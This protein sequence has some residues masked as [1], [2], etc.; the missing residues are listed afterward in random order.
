M[1]LALVCDA[2]QHAHLA[3][4][5]HRDLK[6]SNILVTADGQPKVLDFGVARVARNDGDVTRRTSAGELLGTL[7]YMSPEQVSGDPRRVDARSDVYALGVLLYRLL[8]GMLPLDVERLPVP[9]A[10]RRIAEDDPMRLGSIDRRL[11][12]DLEVIAQKALEKDRARRYQSA[13]ELAADLRR[14]LADE[15]I[16]ARG[17]SRRYQLVKFARRHR[18]LAGGAVMASLALVAG[19]VA[20]IA[21]AVRADSARRDAVDESERAR[22]ESLTSDRVVEFLVGL[23]QQAG[24]RVARGRTI[25]AKEVL[26]SGVLRLR[27]ELTDEPAVRA[28]LVDTLVAVYQELGLFRDAAS[29]AD[30]ALRLAR[31]LNGDGSVAHAK[32]LIQRAAIAYALSEFSLSRA[33]LDDAAKVLA[34]HPDAESAHTELRLERAQ[35]LALEGR[36]AE[37]LLLAD[38]VLANARHL[39]SPTDESI[40]AL[41]ACGEIAQSCGAYTAAEE[42]FRAALAQLEA[43][44]GPGS[45]HSLTV[46]NSLGWTLDSLGRG[47]ESEEC[48]R[49]LLARIVELAPDG[50]PMS[51]AVEYGLATTL[52]GRGKRAEAKELLYGAIAT[53]EAR[54]G[55]LSYGLSSAASQLAWLHQEDGE[56]DLAEPLARRV[57]EIDE[58]LFGEGSEQVTD[59]LR[60]NAFV[61]GDLGRSAEARE[62]QE[63]LLQRYSARDGSESRVVAN[64]LHSLGQ[65]SFDLGELERAQR[66]LQDSIR[67]TR[68]L[69][70]IPDD[71]GKVTIA[72]SYVTLGQVALEDGDPAAAAEALLQALNEGSGVWDAADP[73]PVVARILCA[74]ALAGV[75]RLQ[76]ARPL[77]EEARERAAGRKEFESYGAAAGRFLEQLDELLREQAGG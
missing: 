65:L 53:W 71:A 77:L 76:E 8:T 29:L 39:D 44:H 62:V 73:R 75:G 16:V 19:T 4:V 28:R 27:T 11:R 69:A 18:G 66:E 33:L 14:F 67:L 49:A 59:A 42:R 17:P 2:V 22:R 13:A 9:E 5:V 26:D 54:E 37:A 55:T 31:E 57:L 51:T 74:Q 30:E 48:L 36:H 43:R 56:L 68:A 72:N 47:E 7:P 38:E 70:P 10:V 12:G 64:T 46:Q 20:S 41:V 34:A 35:G 25:T 24:P 50:H 15:P 58:K 1:L 32:A 40:Q 61:L 52:A 45:F 6:P 3:G 60:L 23:F 63:R 21:F